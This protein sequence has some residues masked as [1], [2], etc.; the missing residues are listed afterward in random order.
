VKA[1]D[2]NATAANGAKSLRRFI[3]K[4][5]FALYAHSFPVDKECLIQLVTPHQKNGCWLLIM[6]FQNAKLAFIAE[7]IGL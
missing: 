6:I 5:I 2:N 1:L 7:I 4:T 3:F